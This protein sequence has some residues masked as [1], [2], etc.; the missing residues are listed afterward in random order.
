[1]PRFRS[2]VAVLDGFDHA[3]INRGPRWYPRSRLPGEGRLIYIAG[4][5][6]THGAPFRHVAELTHG[7]RVVIVTPYATASYV[8]TSRMTISGRDLA[9]LRSPAHEMLRLQT[10][11]V[12]AGSRR[13]LVTATLSTI[14]RGKP[15]VRSRGCGT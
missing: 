6:R 14:R 12:P 8:V 13:I 10:S 15:D 1:M 3:T 4:H 5:H 7:D 9:V 2:E 11:T